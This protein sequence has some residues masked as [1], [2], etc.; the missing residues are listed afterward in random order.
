M[1]FYFLDATEDD[2]GNVRRVHAERRY[3]R[4]RGESGSVGSS[5][6]FKSF[7]KKTIIYCSQYL[8]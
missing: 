5:E 6:V 2:T 3:F 4:L 8:S 1:T 7:N